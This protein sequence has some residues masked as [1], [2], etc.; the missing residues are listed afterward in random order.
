[1]ARK[2]VGPE[3]RSQGLT[4]CLCCCRARHPGT[5]W[6][7]GLQDVRRG[8]PQCRLALSE[9]VILRAGPSIV[10]L[11]GRV[12]FGVLQMEA[13]VWRGQASPHQTCGLGS[14]TEPPALPQV[15]LG[16]QAWEGWGCQPGAQGVAFHVS[17][18]SQGPGKVG[19]IQGA[20]PGA[21]PVGLPLS[22]HCRGVQPAPG[23]LTR[24]ARQPRTS[25]GAG[26]VRG[27]EGAPREVPLLLASSPSL[28]LSV[29]EMGQSRSTPH[30]ATAGVGGFVC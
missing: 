22:E 10:A 5:L 9:A 29:C 3:C 19:G 17:G 16:P 26:P 2:E 20:H 1:M 18:S 21:F 30:R 24:L 12:S 23:L 4:P 8:W 27:G 7:C 15:E 13:Q 28:T 11:R 6:E 25:P 14:A